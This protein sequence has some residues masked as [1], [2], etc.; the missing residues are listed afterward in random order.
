MLIFVY[1]MSFY[2]YLMNYRF[3]CSNLT[4]ESD[5]FEPPSTIAL[6]L[7]DNRL[8]LLAT[9]LKSQLSMGVPVK[10]F[11]IFSEHLFLRTPLG[12]CLWIRLVKLAT[13]K[14]SKK[15]NVHRIQ[16]FVLQCLSNELIS[17]S[18]N[19]SLVG[20]SISIFSNTNALSCLYP[21]PVSKVWKLSSID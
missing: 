6:L 7:Q 9:L 17:L 1:F 4:G 14:T 15:I 19:L 18:L 16:H 12:G 8:K 3:F 5:W 20:V 11:C 21:V 13:E 10:I 2:F